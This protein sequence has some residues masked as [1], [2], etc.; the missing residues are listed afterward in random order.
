VLQVHLI[1]KSEP[2]TT[3]IQRWT[4]TIIAI[5]IGRIVVVSIFVIGIKSIS[6]TIRIPDVSSTVVVVV[7]LSGIELDIAH[8]EVLGILEKLHLRV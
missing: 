4:L 3:T 6:V 7:S 2:T 5:I 8:R 1:R